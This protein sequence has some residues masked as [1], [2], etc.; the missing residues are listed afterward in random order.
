MGL[1]V[2]CPHRTLEPIFNRGPVN[3]LLA[4]PSVKELVCGHLK[5][6]ARAAC[7]DMGKVPLSIKGTVKLKKKNVEQYVLVPV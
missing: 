4:H 2:H 7:S 6:L 1:K 5:E 3:S